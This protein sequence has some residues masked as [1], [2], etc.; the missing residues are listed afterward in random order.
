M[1]NVFFLWFWFLFRLGLGLG[2]L[3]CKKHLEGLNLFVCTF[4]VGLELK[5]E[6]LPVNVLLISFNL[7]LDHV[8][9][10]VYFDPGWY[11]AACLSPELVANICVRVRTQGLRLEQGHVV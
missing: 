8:S 6:F 9:A 4:E 7:K 3:F 2:W 11:L 5:I 10:G 1:I